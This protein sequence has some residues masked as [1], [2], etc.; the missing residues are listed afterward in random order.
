MSKPAVEL[1]DV[2]KRFGD[3]VVAIDGID[4]TIEDGEFFSL[5]VPSG[6]AKTTTLRLT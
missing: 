5:L 3:D 6:C 2:T 4:F 1:V